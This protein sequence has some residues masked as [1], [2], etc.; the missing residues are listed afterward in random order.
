MEET[1]DS[2]GKQLTWREEGIRIEVPAGAV[3][4]GKLAMIGVRKYETV[5]TQFTFLDDAEPIS[6]VYELY[7]SHKV[8]QE[9]IQLSFTS[10]NPAGTNQRCFMQASR[11][12]RWKEDFTPEYQFSCIPGGEFKPQS[13]GTIHLERLNC[14]LVVASKLTLNLTTTP[15]VDIPINSHCISCH[16]SLRSQTQATLE[17]IVWDWRHCISYT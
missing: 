2:R 13:G 10:I 3:P 6:P 5:H 8:F 4:E 15:V 11:V 12:P 1:V 14:Y 7:C 9:R 17:E 16:I